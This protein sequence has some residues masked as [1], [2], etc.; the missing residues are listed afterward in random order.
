[1]GAPTALRLAQLGADGV[2]A[3]NAWGM[4]ASLAEAT[5]AAVANVPL[6]RLGIAEDVGEDVGWL[7]S[8]APY[9]TRIVI[10]ID[11]GGGR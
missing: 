7:G 2:G 11:C 3:A 8:S 1:M 9:V 10:P 4:G 5:R 6:G